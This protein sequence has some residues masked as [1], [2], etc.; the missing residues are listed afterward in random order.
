MRIRLLLVVSMA[1]LFVATAL[2][3]KTFPLTAG[4]SV[5]A[6]SGKI[7]TGKDKNGNIEVTV[8]TEHLA[9][10]GMLTPAATVYVV[11]FKEQGGEPTNEGQYK[12]ENSLKGEFKTTTRLHNFEVFITAETDSTTKVPSDQVVLKAD[13]QV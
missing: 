1:L 3:A 6:A 7:E 10:P 12:V 9:K 13:V 4:Q 11:W 8:K 2:S 5:P